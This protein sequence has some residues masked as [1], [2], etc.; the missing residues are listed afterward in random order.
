LSAKGFKNAFRSC[1]KPSKNFPDFSGIYSHF[2]LSYFYLL[3]GSKTFYM[4]SKYFIWIVHVP[5]CLREF[6]WNFCDFRCIFRAFKQ[7]LDFFWNCF[8]LKI[9]SK[10]K[11]IYPI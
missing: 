10:K 2:S 8:A 7:V 4:S 5:M 9:I 6:S 11:K 1:P 3:E